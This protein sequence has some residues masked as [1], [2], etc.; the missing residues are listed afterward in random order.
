MRVRFLPLVSSC[1]D[2]KQG[3][4]ITP[5]CSDLAVKHLP[6]FHGYFF[7]TGGNKYADDGRTA[8]P[9]TLA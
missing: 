8:V 5:P 9:L 3:V 2:V 6:M 7:T 4:P 1:P